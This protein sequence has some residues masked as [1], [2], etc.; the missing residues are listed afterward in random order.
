ML[1]ITVQEDSSQWRLHLAG[2]LGG[3]WVAETENTW[4]SAP[5]SGRRLEIDLGEVTWVDDARRRLPQAMNQ[6][7]ARLIAEGSDDE[8]L[9]EEIA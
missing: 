2:R 8:A 3:L 7:G 1:R 5:S 4:R 6:A 9:V